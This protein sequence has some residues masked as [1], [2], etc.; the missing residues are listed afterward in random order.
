M[1]VV[2][3]T[4]KQEQSTLSKRATLLQLY[5]IRRDAPLSGSTGD[6][7]AKKVIQKDEVAVVRR[8]W[9]PRTWRQHAILFRDHPTGVSTLQQCSAEAFPV[10]DAFPKVAEET[11]LDSFPDA[12]LTRFQPGQNVPIDVFGVNVNGSRQLASQN[13]NRVNASDPEMSS[14]NAETGI[15]AVN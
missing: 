15:S 12:E 13:R 11:G 9:R 10:D 8:I 14:V 4:T 5:F 3:A 6:G 2:F 7:I 1:C